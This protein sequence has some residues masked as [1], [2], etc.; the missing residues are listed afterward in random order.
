MP[1]SS[2]RYPGLERRTMER[3]LQSPPRPPAD[4]RIQLQTSLAAIVALF[5]VTTPMLYTAG[6]QCQTAYLNGFGVQSDLFPLA[7]Q[8]YLIYGTAAFLNASA[9]TFNSLF[10]DYYQLYWQCLA[11]M[12]LA[13]LWIW[14]IDNRGLVSISK[15]LEISRTRRSFSTIFAIFFAGPI[16]TFVLIIFFLAVALVIV[17]FP[18]QIGT[19]VGKELAQKKMRSLVPCRMFTNNERC[20]VLEKNG[21]VIAR[22]YLVATS[23][24]FLAIYDDGTTIIVTNKDTTIS[25]KTDVLPHH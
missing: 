5:A 23:D 17:L 18:F 21:K 6:K 7:T 8:D 25:V 1:L 22:G 13:A 14:L 11:A 9:E 10:S 16:A 2:P 12:L 4:W 24:K 3:K 19:D 20:T 15:K